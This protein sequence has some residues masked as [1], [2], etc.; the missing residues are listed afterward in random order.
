M[1]EEVPSSHR[2]KGM[3]RG[4]AGVQAAVLVVPGRLSGPRQNI[5]LGPQVCTT[6]SNNQGLGPMAFVQAT[7]VLPQA[8][9]FIWGPTLLS[10]GFSS[11]PHPRN[12][13]VTIYIILRT[14]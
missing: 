9:A 3:S 5:L 4:K 10:W 1:T 7:L 13:W 14:Q 12:T 2:Q 8:G 11:H 6:P